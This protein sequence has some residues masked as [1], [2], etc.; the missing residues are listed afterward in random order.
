VTGISAI[1]LQ[2]GISR[3]G[4]PGFINVAPL[5]LAWGVPL[6]S[7]WGGQHVSSKTPTKCLNNEAQLG[8]IT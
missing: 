5:G 6:S 3:G 2:I 1:R 7:K 4:A 8:A